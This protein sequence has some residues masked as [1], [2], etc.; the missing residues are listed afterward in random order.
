MQILIV[1]QQ[2]NVLMNKEHL[3]DPRRN[4]GRKLKFSHFGFGEEFMLQQLCC[5]RP[6]G[7]GR[8]EPRFSLMEVSECDMNMELKT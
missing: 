5:S 2:I 7:E 8:A 3:Q 6:K 1:L 4:S